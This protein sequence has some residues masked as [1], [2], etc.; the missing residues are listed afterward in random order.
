MISIEGITNDQIGIIVRR[1]VPYPKYRGCWYDMSIIWLDERPYPT[2]EEIAAEFIVFM[3]EVAKAN[4]NRKTWEIYHEA[5]N[6]GYVCEDG[7][8]YMCDKDSFNEYSQD[9]F[10]MSKK[11]KIKVWDYDENVIE[12]DN[13]KL[14]K[15]TGE[16]G[17]YQYS[18]RK[19]L[20]QDLQK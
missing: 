11:E 18:L 2:D 20:W 5:M 14:K 16:I 6:S 15:M 3:A 4:H 12:L 8:K 13:T 17:R 9:L 10:I 1:L 7:K 19:I